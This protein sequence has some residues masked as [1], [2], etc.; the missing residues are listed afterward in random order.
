MPGPS[1]GPRAALVLAAVLLFAS[2]LAAQPS[3]PQSD[4]GAWFA[5]DVPGGSHALRALGVADDRERGGVMIEL[6]RRLYFSTTAPLQ[7]EAVLASLAQAVTDFETL[8]NAVALASP[9][10]KPPTLTLAGDKKLR[11]RIEE[12]LDAAGLDLKEN[13]KQ[14][15]VEL[16]T[17]DKA[18]ALRKRLLDIGIDAEG[19]RKGFNDGGPLVAALPVTR[20]PLPLSPQTWAK[21]V[22]ER[23]IPARRLFVEIVSDPSARLLYHGLA[24]MDAATRRWM[25]A[26][27]D[28]LRRIYRDREAV[29]AFSLFGP[30]I[31]VGGGKVVVAG[32]VIAERRWSAVLDAPSARPDQFVRRLLDHNGGRTAGLYFTIAAVDAARQ[33]FLLGASETGEAG[34]RRF[35][36]LVSSFANCYPSNSTQYPFGLRSFDAALLLLEVGI[37]D[38]GELAGP[39]WRRFWERVLDGDSLPD[40]PANALREIKEDGTVDAAW[41]VDRLCGASSMERGGVFV[42]ILAGQRTFAGV[43]DGDLPNALVAL[44]ARRLYPAVFMALEHA[45]V[46]QP[47]VYAAIARRAASMAQLDDLENG[48]TALRL[49]QG[50]L[51][52]TANAMSATTFTA[53]GESLLASL[54]EVSF[55]DG[56]YRGRL[57]E[58]MVS[59]WL[60]AARKASGRSTGSSE[61]IVAQAL[62]GPIAGDLPR[63][64][65]EGQD[66]VVDLSGTAFQRLVEVRKKQ[67]GPPLDDVLALHQVSSALR[68]PAITLERVQELRGEL[69]KLGLRL[70]AMSR[71]AEYAEEGPKTGEEIADALNDL[72]RVDEA[73]DL[74]RAKDVGADLTRLTDFMLAHVLGAWAY[75]PYLGDADG[76]SL[77]GGDPSLR[78]VLGLS[79]SG[80]DKLQQR[81]ELAIP[82]GDSRSIQGSLLGLQGGLAVW[83]LHR[84][85]ADNVPP[86]PTIGGNDLSSFLLTAS[87]SNPRRLEDAAL[88]RIASAIAAGTKAVAGAAGNADALAATAAT[89][90][91]SPWRREALGWTAREEPAMLGQQF[92]ITELARLGGLAPADLRN[93]GSVS[94]VTGCLCLQAPP[95]RI[96]EVTVG[97]AADGLLGGQSAD[98]MLRIA[99]ILAELKMPASL[100]SQ[101][102]SYAMRDFLDRVAPTHA[103]DFDAFRRQAAALDRAAIEDYLGALSAI[104][105]L[106]LA[107]APR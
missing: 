77:I 83:S 34:S 23:D 21:V 66:Y 11:K 91:M 65:W 3:A 62:A 47:S 48:V 12:A 93:W 95:S 22:F 28:L 80:R 87:L 15:R 16:H 30:A 56:R 101:V 45:G 81:W 59:Q 14:F 32:G 7:L 13:R 74:N 44:R 90:A 18:V 54:A 69:Q 86:P 55:D 10:G 25:A 26:Q 40:D 50:A 31:R 6:V 84:L 29:R 8:R 104:G 36:R 63:L 105:P 102:M 57:A 70:S 24:G 58:W 97:R 72:G 9:T 20:L 79:A 96:P 78:H 98:L 76:G 2:P 4:E 82:G 5:L 85:S 1:D 89:A 51:A 35:E 107:G 92:S 42:T 67:A 68:Q 53:E 38:D 27:P 64:R 19:V 39:V 71:A 46:R 99:A 52:L 88:A 103:A 49:Y 61:E 75:A 106:R 37:T 100:A 41:L 33:K 73:R 94:I 60:P 17:N 43:A